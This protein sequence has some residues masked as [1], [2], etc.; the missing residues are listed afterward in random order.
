MNKEGYYVAYKQG[1][2]VIRSWHDTL[3]AAQSQFESLGGHGGCAKVIVK[4]P[5]NRLVH[6]YPSNMSDPDVVACKEKAFAL[7]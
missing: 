3:I 7:C 4:K 2:S 6:A 5:E 1:A